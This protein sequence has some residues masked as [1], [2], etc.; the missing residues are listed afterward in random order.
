MDIRFIEA[1]KEE[2]EKLISDKC[3]K[4]GIPYSTP[5]HV[6]ELIEQANEYDRYREDVEMILFLSND[7]GGR[8]DEPL[9]RDKDD[10]GHPYVSFSN[11]TITIK[12]KDWGN[13]IYSTLK[14][15][16]GESKPYL[17]TDKEQLKRAYFDIVPNEAKKSR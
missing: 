5:A 15:T 17:Y 16:V 4:Y 13:G 3:K 6:I 2:H 11:R 12:L 10:D 8:W 7:E 14:S 1:L 9:Y